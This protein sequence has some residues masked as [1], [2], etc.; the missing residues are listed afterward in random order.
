M[1]MFLGF[2]L[3]IVGVANIALFFFWMSLVHIEISGA[4]QKQYVYDHIATDMTIF[5][6]ILALIMVGAFIAVAFGYFTMKQGMLRSA[7]KQV[8]DYLKDRAPTV[9]KQYLSSLDDKKI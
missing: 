9:V 5:E 3:G 7:F 4:D 1:K 8:D 6:V 2:L